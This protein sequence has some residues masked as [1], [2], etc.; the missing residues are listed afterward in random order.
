MIKFIDNT[1]EYFAS[2]YF[3]EDFPKKVRDK[4]GL[5]Q[6]DLQ[7]FNKQLTPL[8]ERY[9]RFKNNF[10]E[11]R[12]TKDRVTETH[13]FHTQLLDLLG[14][15]AAQP[16]YEHLYLLNDKEGIPVR[17]KL[18]R[19]TQ[20]HLFVMEMQSVMEEEDQT[21]GIFDQRYHR[22][23][24]VDVFHF[25]E[26]DDVT[27]TP[28]H[29]YKAAS[30]L[31]MLD[32]RRRPTYVLLLAAPDI[33][34]MHYEKWYKGSY[35]RFNLESLFDEQSA[36][37]DYF[38]L[39]YMLVGREFLAPDA[40]NILVEQLDEDSHK[41]AHAVT[42]DL[43]DGVVHAVEQL[44]NEAVWYFKNYGE[45][46]LQL[47]PNFAEELK[48]DCLTYVYRLLF[49]F[50]AESRPDLALLPVDD[51]VYQKGYSLERLR[52]MEQVPLQSESSRSGYFF[53]QSLKTLF[54]LLE[55]GYRQN[56]GSKLSR[57][58]RVQPID[59]PLFQE[60]RLIHLKQVRFRNVVLQDIIQ[61]LS[62]SKKRRN[63]TRGRISYANLDI[64]Q[65]GSVYESLLAYRGFFAEEDMIEVQSA[66]K[67]D[68][69]NNTFVVPRRRRGDFKEDEIVKD[70]EDAGRDI[71]IP[72]DTFVYRL[73][74][75][76]R[77]K[78]A[79]YYTPEVLT[80]T[81]VKYTLKPILEKLESGELKSR[82]LLDLKVLEPAMGAAA[83]HNEL[84][85]QLA[86]AYL[87]YAQKERKDKISPENYQRRLQ[88]TKTWLATRNLY[89][90]DINPAALELGKLAL[91]L[92][93]MHP[94][95]ETPFFGHR[96][97]AGNAVVGCWRRVYRPE[98]FRRNPKNKQA[99]RKWWEYEPKMTGFTR[100]GKS[101]RR[102]GDIYQFL[103]PDGNMV[104]AAGLKWFKDHFHSECTAIRNWKKRFIE[105]LAT[106]EYNLL[107]WISAEIDKLFE[108]HYLDQ[109][110]L[111]EETFIPVNLYGQ[112]G[113]QLKA[114]PYDRKEELDR[115]RLKDSAPY[116]KLKLIMDYWCSLWYWHPE[117]AR[118]LPE[119]HD[120]YRDILTILEAD[121]DE[122]KARY[123]S[124]QKVGLLQKQVKKVIKPEWQQGDAFRG[125]QLGLIGDRDDDAVTAT[126]DAIVS[127]DNRTELFENHRLKIVRD[128]AVKY[129]FFHYELDFVEVFVVRGGFDVIAG[130][131]PWIKMEFDETGVV[132]ELFPEVLTRKMKTPKV[133][134]KVPE[135][136]SV[137][138]MPEMYTREY[139]E[140]E[141]TSV[142]LNS[143]A[144]HPN[145]IGQQTNL[146]RCVLDNGLRM[147]SKEGQ[148]GLLHPEGVYNDP[149]GSIFRQLLYQR[150]M[151]RLQF[152]N[153]L[154]LFAQIGHREKFSVNVY[155]G[156]SN[157]VSF[158]VINNLFNPTTIDGCFVH[159]GSG[160]CGGIKIMN[161]D[162]KPVWNTKPHKSRIIHYTDDVLK[163]IARTFE[164]SDD[165]KGTKLVSIHVA[166]LLNILYKIGQFEGRRVS[167]V[168]HFISEGWHETNAIDN[169]IIRR[170]T[171]YPDIDNYEMIYSGPHFFVG[172][173]L[174][175]TPKS[176]CIEK[177]DYDIID[178]SRI[179]VDY[180]PRTNYVPDMPLSEFTHKIR[181]FEIGKD[182]NGK[183]LNDKWVDYYKVIF[184]KMLSLDGE[185]TLQPSLLPPKAS[186]IHGVIS[187]TF[188]EKNF[189]TEICGI[190]SSILF[191]FYIKTI[192]KENLGDSAIKFFPIGLSENYKTPLV[193]RTLLLNCINRYYQNLWNS[194][195]ALHTNFKW[196]ISDNRLSF[197]GMLLGEWAS[198]KILQ[199]FFERRQALVEIDVLVAM[200][201]GITLEELLLIYRVQFPVL[202]Q[203]ENDTWYDARGNIIF[204]CSKGL[205][206]VG[207]DRSEWDAIAKE[208]GSNRRI[209]K[210]GDSYTQT[211]EKSELYRGERVTYYP[212]FNR[213]D[214]EEDYRVAWE[215]FEQELI[216]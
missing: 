160:V 163:K 173:P 215:H 142:F 64:N 62:L 24:W 109:R 63:G 147:L 41:S 28:S 166:P 155:S 127:Y 154:M 125:V 162:N 130:N 194:S 52:D 176:V 185:R 150:L 120:W 170:E 15:E 137:K 60:R 140:G 193:Q 175:K 108:Q 55:R 59:S 99:G 43:K 65:L 198:K 205:T 9:F 92:N 204:T 200:A 188:Q 145:L 14:Y 89:G 74:G 172:N 25:S 182:K 191:D 58:F 22:S 148:M 203:N 73:S 100:R 129:R 12:R 44:A 31:F 126:I 48:D 180:L 19:G 105:P 97:A 132:A 131:P 4:A 208:D 23:Q 104:P 139:L 133:R 121:V 49:L 209:L 20:P 26:E 183:P 54:R 195:D 101:H 98:L 111:M 82:D 103:L 87:Q 3:D 167:D 119:R 42:K 61:R 10:L 201:L 76:D 66:G 77:Q 37:R 146:Y 118:E 112:E 196:S 181:G 159:D 47:T 18:Y 179:P 207:L 184:S 210:K 16:E 45:N 38:A 40:E 83:F 171:K 96:F 141:G 136:L 17:H 93:V 21:G 95:M 124:M 116:A 57:T 34:L 206:G 197:T 192:G 114:I 149:N 70:E 115:Q 27:L 51:P 79:S 36:N 90:V 138:G 46:G 156:Q 216:G 94:A 67:K 1:G 5:I 187:I 91:W 68:N 107:V 8:R 50:Y 56:E 168:K 84:L 29:I 81:T 157:E 35:L 165:W 123:E 69:D 169:G 152:R 161:A 39:F 128:S 6:T 158:Y 102:A 213:C 212:P 117:Q 88:E 110:A 86:D 211:I 186:H 75:R 199:N 143:K 78:T 151:F 11:L 122:L 134:K 135:F 178:L 153:Q 7:A 189:T 2:N 214:R 174:Y 202:Q 85:N 71:I 144:N 30:E 190:C 106:E 33:Y 13:H 72:K 32:Q 177:A 80:R 53:D 113:A 164:D